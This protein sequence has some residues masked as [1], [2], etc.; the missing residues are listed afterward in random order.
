MIHHDLA[1]IP[2]FELPKGFL[3]RPYLKGDEY[4]WIEIHEHADRWNKVDLDLYNDVFSEHPIAL[5]ERQFYLLDSND[6]PIG[7][8]TAWQR[9]LNGTLIGLI[10]WVAIHPDFQ[11]KGLSKP[12]LSATCARLFE[13]GFSKA[14]LRTSTARIAAINLYWKFGFRP[15]LLDENDKPVWKQIQSHIKAS[16]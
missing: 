14:F 6:K 3:I 11:G 1:T 10:H 15:L 9:E 16:D 12:L 8:A 5:E 13:H 4:H 7:T 2:T